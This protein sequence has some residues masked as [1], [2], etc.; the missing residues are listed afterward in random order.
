MSKMTTFFKRLKRRILMNAAW[1]SAFG[2]MLIP[3]GVVL[4]IAKP[5]TTGIAFWI[6]IGGFF[7]FII[8]LALTVREDKEKRKRERARARREI[9]SYF[10]L[11][12]IASALGV[13]MDELFK[14]EE[15]LL[16]EEKDDV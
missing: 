3:V 7:S 5:E 4:M 10:V 14:Q 6:V 8:G 16:Q 9:A 11:T 2:A 15:T 1:W 13:D 12:H